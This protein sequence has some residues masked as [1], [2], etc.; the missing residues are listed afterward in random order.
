LD[1]VGL[2]QWYAVSEANHI[3]ANFVATLDGG[4]EIGSRS[5][6]LAGEGDHRA[7]QALRCLADVVLVG[8]GTVR[9]ENYGPARL[10]ADAQHRRVN[11][12]QSR[13]P[14]IA[15]ITRSAA[16]DP[17][18]RLFGDEGGPKPLV[19]TASAAPSEHLQALARVA[20]VVV[21]GDDAVDVGTAIQALAERGLAHV[22]CE[23]GPTVLGQLATQGLL[24][25]L[26]L[27]HSPLL[28][29]PGHHLLSA[30]GRVDTGIQQQRWPVRFHATRVLW[31]DGMLLVRYAAATPNTDRSWD[32]P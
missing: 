1:E 31:D 21:C 12:G 13:V 5:A 4:V 15:V 23:G 3:R 14:P 22:L 10:S 24:D 25:E 32:G 6:P 30:G 7:F 28:A 26:C 2:E 16:L 18:S 9:A 19:L 11:R 29:G 20:E 17:G 27:T 8:A